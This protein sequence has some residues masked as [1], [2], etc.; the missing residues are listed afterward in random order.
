MLIKI[1]DDRCSHCIPIG[2]KVIVRPRNKHNVAVR[3]IDNPHLKM[4]YADIGYAYV[5]HKDYTIKK[6]NKI[7]K[8]VLTLNK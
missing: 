1:I 8:K 7:Y 5:I 6:S 2:S 4:T 3:Y